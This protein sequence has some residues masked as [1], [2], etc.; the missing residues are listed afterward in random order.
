MKT[1]IKEFYSGQIFANL[2]L[3]FNNHKM[4]MREQKNSELRHL[5]KNGKIGEAELR[6]E[7][8]LFNESIQ[9]FTMLDFCKCLQINDRNQI[10]NMFTGDIIQHMYGKTIPNIV[11]TGIFCGYTLRIPNDKVIPKHVQIY[12]HINFEKLHYAIMYGE[13]IGDRQMLCDIISKE[14]DPNVAAQWNVTENIQ[15]LIEEPVQ[16]V[17]RNKPF[18]N[19]K[20]NIYSYQYNNIK[21]MEKVERSIDVPLKFLSPDLYRV[22]VYDDIVE[23]DDGLDHTKCVYMDKLRGRFFTESGNDK[24]MLDPY[25]EKIF[26]RGGILADEMG[27]GKTACMIIHCLNNPGQKQSVPFDI[28]TCVK[29]LDYER[30]I[31]TSA[32]LVFVPNQCCA[33]WREEI[34][35]TTD[36][37]VNIIMLAGKKDYELLKYKDIVNADFV[38]CP[39]SFLKN[40]VCM[41]TYILPEH[42][43]SY[44]SRLS[45]Y[46]FESLRN[47]DIFEQSHP[48]LTMFYWKRVILDEAHE[49]FQSDI[50]NN[51]QF[52]ILEGISSE[53]RW[54]MSGTPYASGIDGFHR[55]TKWLSSNGTNCYTPDTNK[56][57]DMNKY[58]FAQFLVKNIE[59]L[60]PRLI[61]RNTN[62]STEHETKLPP[63]IEKEVWINFTEIE[64]AMYDDKYVSEYSPLNSI[65]LRQ[66]CCYPQLNAGLSNCKS[67]DEIHIQ[68]INN[69]KH[70]IELQQK[71]KKDNETALR[72]AETNMKLAIE[73]N[74]QYVI[75]D[76][77]RQIDMYKARITKNEAEIEKL[78]RSH[79]FLSNVIPQIKSGKA[80]ECAICLDQIVGVGVTKCGHVFCFKCI[81][82]QMSGAT[83]NHM[84]PTCRTNLSQRDIYQVQTKK[85]VNENEIINPELKKLVGEYGSKLANIIMFLRESFQSKNDHI[86]IFSQW[87][88][89]LLTVGE[90]LKRNQIDYVYCK[91]NRLQ[92]EKA[93]RLFNGDNNVRV[94]LL[95]S[96][97]ASA[98]TNLTK[99]NKIYFLEPVYGNKKFK[100]DIESQAIGRAH[101]LGQKRPLTI[102][103]FL[104]KDTIEEQIYK[105]VEN[106][107]AFPFLDV[108]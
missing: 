60:R 5:L 4:V 12:V 63:I 27:R 52:K 69:T 43:G 10:V 29:Q 78:T 90:V 106:M 97:Y 37:P 83:G 101:R 82:S 89:L 76:Y 62:K 68:L 33:Q 51:K 14:N 50:S 88:K 23:E 16:Y 55:L 70:E 2:T 79:N 73:R 75:R 34:K 35:L 86:I 41:N 3:S 107:D 26:L 102:H 30:Y 39:Y 74:Q 104:M 32:T 1:H 36:F 38:I 15:K 56:M 19:I 80:G 84:C 72:L 93:I 98:G 6:A 58:K 46:R 99:A 85:E 66:F 47:N 71:V 92:R 24:I 48:L 64:K 91:G 42:T 81:S 40:S 87:N 100:E 65:F 25:F 96:E 105:G 9:N 59:R 22:K 11:P 21:W 94:I 8:D 61:R 20:R 31:T 7:L 17:M 53:F 49:V 44:F 28:K 18:K 54:G 57:N 103:R 77:S 108:D 95:S 45:T 67:M 13:K